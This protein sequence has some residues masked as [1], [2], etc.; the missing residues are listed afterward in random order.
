MNPT[1]ASSNSE[2]GKLIVTHSM[3]SDILLL[4][5]AMLLSLFIKNIIISQSKACIPNRMH[6]A[7]ALIPK[8]Q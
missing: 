7:Y 4:H 8:A 6:S 5:Y 1:Q 3:T 2:L